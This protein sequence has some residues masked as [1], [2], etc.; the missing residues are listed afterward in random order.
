MFLF[1]LIQNK[2]N[3]HRFHS[4]H[5]AFQTQCKLVLSVILIDNH[6]QFLADE[7]IWKLLLSQYNFDSQ[8]SF[9]CA[10]LIENKAMA[11]GDKLDTLPGIDDRI[12]FWEHPHDI[13]IESYATFVC[14]Y[15]SCPESWNISDTKRLTRLDGC[16]AR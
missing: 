2:A 10:I 15:K 6:F 16:D 3:I 1:L 4:Y 8:G 7:T 11:S 12:V 5:F 9:N 14:V 13:N